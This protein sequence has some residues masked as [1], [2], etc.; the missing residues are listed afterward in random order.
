MKNIVLILVLAGIAVALLA[1]AKPPQK[2]EEPTA[3][4]G[5]VAL[6]ELGV[7][8]SLPQGLSGLAVATSSN[9]ALGTIFHIG[10]LSASGK[11]ED[12]CELGVFYRISKEMVVAGTAGLSQEALTALVTGSAIEPPRAKEFPEFYFIFEPAQAVCST[13]PEA[14]QVE[15]ALRQALWLSVGTA[16][17]LPEGEAHSQ[18]IESYIR[19]HIGELSPVPESVGGTFYV[20]AITAQDGVGS[21]SY[22][23]GH[24]AYTAEFTYGVDALGAPT[25]TS[26]VV[27]T[28]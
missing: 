24:N 15:M 16:D 21:V 6:T 1:V 3:A 2:A 17:L 12:T 25:V 10:V 26:F 9:P 13:T 23:D 8:I 11:N 18:T 7:V 19:T 14:A 5:A 4:P 22:E 28:P 27:H 20:T